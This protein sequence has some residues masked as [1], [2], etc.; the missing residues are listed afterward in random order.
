MI[1]FVIVIILT[2]FT[3]F[4][5]DF[6]TA[7][8][9]AFAFVGGEGIS[10]CIGGNMR[11]IAANIYGV[12]FL[13]GWV[14][15]LMC[16]LYMVEHN[17]NWLFTYDTINVFIPNIE[18]IIN[19]GN[20]NL[21]NIYQSIFEDF[22]LFSQR[23]IYI[24]HVYSCT[25]GVV[26]KAI[27]GNLYFGLQASTLFLYGFV[28]VVLVKIFRNY[29]FDEDKSYRHTL[30][31]CLL[32]IL[33]FYSSLI[34]RDIHVLLCYL[35]VF[36]LSGK[37]NFS[38]KTIVELILIVLITC[39]IRIESGL[40]LFL[41]IPAYL[42]F[43]LQK[44]N[45]YVYVLVI[46]VLLAL[47]FVSWYISKRELIMDLYDSTSNFYFESVE[48]GSGIIALFQRIPILGDFLSILYNAS[49]PIPVWIR[50]SPTN[51]IY[52]ANAENIMTFPRISAS[53]FNV[54]TYV[55]V[56]L[57]LF[58]KGIRDKVH[59]ADA[60]KYQLWIGLVF[61]YIQSA[62]ISQ[63]RLLGYYCVFYILMF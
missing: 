29:G 6:P 12:L 61:L 31:I 17:F 57:W 10:F 1:Q 44:R 4:F 8:L 19:Q 56:L 35:I 39:L 55:Y 49:Q 15:M 47:V 34:M 38:I 5:V 13:V 63:R 40:F 18:N 23:K 43:S 46:S 48:E 7:N 52:G 53:Y 32:S 62:V 33:F 25:W 9:I 3:G 60:H 21:W 16:Y 50:L 59:I 20:N 51:N 14:Y 2:L 22:D 30:I 26:I 41:V 36:Y 28:G 11:K 24:Y 27:G 45:N 58:N 42:L 54:M 37:T